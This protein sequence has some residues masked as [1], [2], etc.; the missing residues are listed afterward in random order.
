MKRWVGSNEDEEEGKTA[1]DLLKAVP[2][3]RGWGPDGEAD[4]E[5]EDWMTVGTGNMHEKVRAHGKEVGEQFSDWENIL[6]PEYV[7]YVEDTVF[8]FYTCPSCSARI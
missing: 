6:S 2:I 7:G 1:V 8:T 4:M 5:V 3:M